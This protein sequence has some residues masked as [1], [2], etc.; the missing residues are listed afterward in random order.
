MNFFNTAPPENITIGWESHPR[1]IREAFVTSP[2]LDNE[3]F[4]KPLDELRKEAPR[5][6]TITGVTEYEALLF[7]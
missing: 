2:S 5:K 3:F 4:P 7:L 6:R 1:P